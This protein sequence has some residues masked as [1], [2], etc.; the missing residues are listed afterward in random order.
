MADVA[1]RMGLYLMRRAIQRSFL[2]GRYGKENAKDIIKNRSIAQTLASVAI[3]RFATGSLPGAAVVTTGMA[4]K[5]LMDR[6]KARRSAEAAGDE[7]LLEQARG[8]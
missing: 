6:S 2:K 3:A 8:E 5:I 7:K 4:A 1:M